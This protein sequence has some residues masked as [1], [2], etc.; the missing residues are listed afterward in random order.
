MKLMHIERNYHTHTKLC[1][2]AKGMP[3]DYVR[4]AIALGMKELGFADHGYVPKSFFPDYAK[5]SVPVRMTEEEFYDIYIPSI[6]ECKEQFSSELKVF[7]GLE[8]EYFCQ[9]YDYY[10]GLKDHLDYLIF[11]Q[12]F[13]IYEGRLYNTYN[14][15]DH[16]SIL[17]YAKCA[18]EA[19]DSGLFTVFAH[20][21]VFMMR[22]RNKEGRWEFDK[23]TEIASRMM[24]ESAIKNNVYLEININGVGN[25]RQIDPVIWAYPNEHFWKIVKKYSGVKMIYGM[26]AHWPEFLENEHVEK[27]LEFVARLGLK[28]NQKL[29]L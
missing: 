22:Y 28:V 2:H 9:H 7:S 6:N 13:F 17:F 20:P 12:H 16:K 11:G 15:I 10:K 26:D 1:R 24:I 23:N 4:K 8:C 3:I 14:D 18:C 29:V 5:N 27:V 25:S 21:D 19:M